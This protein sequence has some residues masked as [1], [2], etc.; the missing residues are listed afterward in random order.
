M[1]VQRLWF[2][3]AG[4]SP[5]PTIHEK[6]FDTPS[7]ADA[8]DSEAGPHRLPDGVRQ[9]QEVWKSSS[10]PYFFQDLG[11]GP[12]PTGRRSL[13]DAISQ[14][15]EQYINVI[16]HPWTGVFITEKGKADW[17]IVWIQ[18]LGNAIIAG[19]LGFLSTLIPFAVPG[20][21]PGTGTGIQS[22]SVTHALI[23]STTF[24]LIVF[25][26][27]IF[28]IGSGILRLVVKGFGA[29]GSFLQQCYTTLLFQVPF[30]VAIS[31]VRLI[32]F[33]GGFFFWFGGL[34]L[35]LYGVVLQ[36]LATMVVHDLPSDKAT[37][38]V[39][40]TAIILIPVTILLFAFLTFIFAVLP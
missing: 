36:I 10:P 24:G 33:I 17:D 31:V 22:P 4:A 35:L 28:F 30:G 3:R 5:A 39:I 40:I 9:G 12:A 11:Y 26:P 34:V 18:L 38:V 1:G 2:A 27:A 20:N 29:Y 13:W 8:D 7:Y 23:L 21:A 6:S 19:V 37:S 14:L 25:I 32:P 15:P 16:T